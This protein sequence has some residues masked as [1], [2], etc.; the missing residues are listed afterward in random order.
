MK[1]IVIAVVAVFCFNSLAF[2]QDVSVDSLSN[3][4]KQENKV[5]TSQE[6][7]YFGED[8]TF[9]L[10][11][12]RLSESEV[13]RTLLGN[14][15]ALEAWEKGNTLKGVNAGMKV[16]TG[17]LI[18]VGGVVTI[19]SFFVAAA[20]ATATLAL[21]PLLVVSDT[22]PIPH[23]SGRWLAAGLCLMGGGI[24]TGI[25]IP[26]TKATYQDHYSNAASI[27]NKSSYKTSVSL[28]IGTTGNG[29][30]VSLKF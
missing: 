16:A 2:S 19:I 6:M 1:K 7:K 25:M 18:T 8:N 28:H 26:L 30:G 10:G 13:R 20:E 11:N 15:S 3:N 9:Y 17:V 12:M 14:T 23:T 29:L 21:L 4:E 5:N 22:D 24:I 27:Y